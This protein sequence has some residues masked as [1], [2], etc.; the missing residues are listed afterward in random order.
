MPD[1]VVFVLFDHHFVVVFAQF[2]SNVLTITFPFGVEVMGAFGAYARRLCA[3]IVDVAPRHD[4]V[5]DK[6]FS[7]GEALRLSSCAALLS[8]YED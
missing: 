3:A 1:D 7:V 6:S 8:E 5:D 4:D 2:V